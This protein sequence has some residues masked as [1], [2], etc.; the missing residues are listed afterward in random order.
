MSRDNVLAEFARPVEIDP[1]RASMLTHEE[2]VA[3]I[4]YEWFGQTKSRKTST[5]SIDSASVSQVSILG[6]GRPA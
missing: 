3:L 5:I 1:R 2:R 6:L 4:L